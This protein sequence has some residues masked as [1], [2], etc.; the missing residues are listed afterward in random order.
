MPPLW[1]R[2]LQLL[3]GVDEPPRPGDALI[4]A[5]GALLALGP[6]AAAAAQRDGLTPLQAAGMLLA[7]ALV[8]PHSVL[9][10]PYQGRAETLASLAV[11]A[12]AGGYGTVALLPWAASWRD[13]PER[14][15]LPWP[16]PLRLRLWGSFTRAGQGEAL[17]PHGEQLAVG[18][19]GLASAAELPPLPLLERGIALGEC[20]G[21]PLLLAPRQQALCAGGFVRASAA[22]LRAGWPPDPLASELL[23]LQLL[24]GLHQQH[25]QLPLLL[26][27]LSPAAGVDLLRR[28]PAGPPPAVTVSWW[29]LLADADGLAPAA[30]G[31]RLE[32]SLGA[33]ADR[34]ALIAALQEGLISAVAVHHQAL[35]REEQLLP[36]D[37]RR[38]GVAGHG[39]AVL[40]LLWR[41]LVQRRGWPVQQLWR[42]LCWQPARLLGLEP[43]GLEPGSRRWLL[44]DPAASVS[45]GSATACLAANGAG[46]DAGLEGAIRASGL[47]AAAQWR[48]PAPGCPSG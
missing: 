36:L 12:A 27:N 7:P 19:V 38:P 24:A 48:L 13:R 9:E 20:A 47:T 28:W 29:H 39:S 41:Q 42:V 43:E 18:A 14:L 1:L 33:A 8:D 10:D 30:V 37:Q 21:R 35:D 3:A 31:W 40:P 16:E 6:Q 34:E 23:P 15:Q 26:M 11:A 17:A 4:A 46:G 2:G 5:D 45:A 25:P 44:F 22:A 32:P